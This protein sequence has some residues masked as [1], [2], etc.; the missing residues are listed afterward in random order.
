MKR[1]MG[2]AGIVVAGFA[3]LAPLAA[4]AAGGTIV[5]M[6][7]PVT[8]ER[9]G[10]SL[11]AS[12]GMELAD[13]DT[14]DSAKGGSAQLR[15]DDD[16]VFVVPGGSALKVEEFRRPR[17]GL[18]GRAIFSLLRGG[19][20]T[21]TGL[22]G[23]SRR[24]VYQVRTGVATIGIRGTAYSAVLC[25]GGNCGAKGKFKDGLY[26]KVDQGV[27]A[28]TN[29]KGEVSLRAGQTAFVESA[30][31]APVRVQLSPF[32][33]PQFDAEFNVDVE[34]QMDVPPPRIEPDP[35]ASPS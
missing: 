7:G 10:Q 1:G 32:S 14:L 26:V 13:G 35:P 3:L 28:V 24:D 6:S 22:V 31:T 9:G 5:K 12:A 16:S 15:F 25:G 29:A 17:A 27:V 19:F 18:D 20:R 4:G 33:D 11:P 2:M 34:F 21:I 30:A 23:R 8:V